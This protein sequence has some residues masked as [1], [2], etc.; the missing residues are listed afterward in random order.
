MKIDHKISMVKMV[1]KWQNGKKMAEWLKNGKIVKK[2][3]GE[4]KWQNG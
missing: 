2:W 3:R 4:K 1:K